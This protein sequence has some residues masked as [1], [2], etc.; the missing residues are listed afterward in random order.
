[1][2]QIHNGGAFPRNLR[3]G[4]PLR[5]IGRSGDSRLT[6]NQKTSLCLMVDGQLESKWSQL[7]YATRTL[8]PVRL[9]LK[10][11]LFLLLQNI[12]LS[13]RRAPVVLSPDHER[14][15]QDR[16]SFLVRR[17]A[18]IS[19]SP[20]IRWIRKTGIKGMARIRARRTLKLRTSQQMH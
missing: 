2:L 7:H 1:M 15:R 18:V 17:A 13:A 5:R 8:S 4:L 11:T 12:C 3:S 14:P 9:V 19:E 20:S 6:P 10:V 16:K